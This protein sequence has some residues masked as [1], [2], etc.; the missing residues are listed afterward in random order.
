MCLK[1][2]MNFLSY[3]V[4]ISAEI[5][6]VLSQFTHVTGRQMDGQTETFAVGKTTLHTMQR[7][8]KMGSIHPPP[9]VFTRT[10]L[11]R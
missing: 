4:R 2:Y 11:L 5:A 10:F 9:D 6:F 7:G 3:G 8:N 1:N